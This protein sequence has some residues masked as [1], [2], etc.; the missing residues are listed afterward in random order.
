MF[1]DDR[2]GI[3]YIGFDQGKV[4]RLRLEENPMNYTEEAET[5]PHTLRI[6]GISVNGPSSL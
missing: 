6:T 2:E 1:W 3:L 5:G 4:V